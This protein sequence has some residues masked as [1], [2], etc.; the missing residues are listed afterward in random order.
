MDKLAEI[1]DWK[2]KEIASRIRP[3]KLEDLESL[4]LR[5][6]TDLSFHDSL[7][8]QDELSIIAE[9]KRKSPS[10]GNIAEKISAVDQA[11]NYLNADADS[12]SV[13][14][15]H[16]YFGGEL[17]DLWD[18]NDFL[19]NHQRIIPTI[20]K[21][22]MVHPIQIMEALEAG[23][24]AILLIVR[25]LD[26]DELKILRE[27]A[28]VSGLDCLYEIHEEAE[29]EKALRH[30]PKILGVNNRDLTRFVTDLKISE[31]LIPKIPDSI[32]KVSESGISEPEDA[33]YVREIG[34]DAVLCGEALMKSE[35]T[36]SLIHS[37]KQ[38]G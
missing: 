17:K 18:V 22:F 9:I 2:R 35:D 38:R 23:A 13:L 30:N 4:G 26:D 11:R 37:M 1:M 20:R 31:E 15:D 19:T 21:D 28:D 10:A 27:A 32:V 6:K 33:W 16:K 36:E 5:M 25:A 3:V 14:T 7:S 12:L 29:L 24:R 34:A 8:N